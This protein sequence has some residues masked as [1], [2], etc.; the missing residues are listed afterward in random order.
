MGTSQSRRIAAALAAAFVLA[1]PP[2]LASGQDQDLD[3][4]R[5]GATP[6]ER[7][8]ACGAVIADTKLDAGMRAQALRQRADIRTLA[9]AVQDAIADYSEALKLQPGAV[10]SLIG[11]ARAR[12]TAGDLPGALLDYGEAV[13]LSP[14]AA[15]LL[16]ERG[17]AQLAAGDLDA[18]IA[19]LN[20]AIVVNPSSSIA[21]NT[22]GLAWR[23][24][25]ELNKAFA[26]YTAAINLNPVYAQ[27]YANRGYLEEGR[28]NKQAAVDDLRS[29]L[30]LD[31]SM[32]SV[33][34]AMTRL[35]KS[36][37]LA[38]ETAK[39]VATGKAL[40]EANCARCHAV[41]PEGASPNAKAPPFRLLH[42]RHPLLALREPLTRGIVTPHDEMPRFAVTTADI[43]VIVAYINSLSTPR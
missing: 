36:D 19:D 13:R 8:A 31:P 34:E 25:G 7:L 12:V 17:H 41:G 43:D 3:A 27:A 23:K 14:G 22:R 39:R 5:R 2:G 4:C 21:Y 16:I 24:K 33:R 18:A 30:A 42:Q 38:E 26:D 15:S 11:R 9:G 29:A 28:G 35:G 1:L 6:E 32:V 10:A 40:V 37:A 20:Q